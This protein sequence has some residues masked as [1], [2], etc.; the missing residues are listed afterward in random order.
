MIPGIAFTASLGLCKS[1]EQE[2]VGPWL[3]MG[4]YDEG[5]LE[6]LWHPKLGE[7]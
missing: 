4:M 2:T 3:G 6:D 1:I 5:G 7:Q